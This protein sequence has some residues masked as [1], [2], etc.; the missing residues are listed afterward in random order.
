MSVNHVC[1]CTAC[2]PDAY[3]NGPRQGSGHIAVRFGTGFER[4]R[5]YWE[6]ALDGELVHD[7]IEALPGQNGY[8]IVNGL[9][10]SG[11]AHLCRT[12]AASIP[13]PM[14]AG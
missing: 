7:L 3:P 8:V 2:A 1:Q 14:P 10:E 11:K 6:A 12:C 5:P 9:D 13:M 4:G